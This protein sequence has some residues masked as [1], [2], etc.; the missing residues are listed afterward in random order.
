MGKSPLPRGVEYFERDKRT[1]TK[2][3]V[4]K[5]AFFSE[6]YAFGDFHKVI[7]LIEFPDGEWIRLGYYVKDHGAPDE[8]F[9]WGSQTTFMLRKIDFETLLGR[10][11]S[12]GII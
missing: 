11:R 9:A 5:E 1:K 6:E 7:Q 3:K 2:G 4:I 8:K 10:A 12:N